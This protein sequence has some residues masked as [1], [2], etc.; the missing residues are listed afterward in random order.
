MS[1]IVR[2]IEFRVLDEEKIKKIH[3]KSLYIME[4]I[5]MR[6][7]GKRAVDLLTAHGARL[8]AD[9]LMRIGADMVE[10]ALQSAPKKLVLYNRSGEEAM[11]IDSENSQ[12]Y[13]GTHSDQ[14][15]IVDPFD[16]GVRKF[17]KKDVATMCRIAN[18]LPHIHFVLSVGMT[19]DV[20]PRVQT[21]STFI[22]TLRHFSKTI[23]FSSNNIDSLKDCLNIAADF[24]GGMQ[25]LQEK[26]F[27]FYYCEPIPPL[28]HPPDSTEKAFIS[29]EHRIPLIYMPYCMM[30]GTSPI[31][32]AT[33]LAQSN[34][35]VLFGL[36]LSQLVSE[37][38][39]Y[40][41]GAMPSILDM[42]T[43]IG[44]Y[45]APEFHLCVAA[46]A[47][48]A[49]YYGLPFYGTAGCSDAKAVD[50]QSVSE[51]T[52]QILS[53]MLSK[54]NLIHDVG[55]LD[56]CNNVSPEMVVLANEIIEMMKYYTRGVDAGEDDFV[57]D[58]V[59]KVGPGGHYIEE[60]HTLENFRQIWYPDI[61]SREKVTQPGSSI[62]QKIRQKIKGILENGAGPTL[63]PGQAEVL[64]EWEKKLGL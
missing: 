16:G 44:S 47:D 33:T 4:K 23:N 52:F 14:L 54:A 10:K 32:L 49:A 38:T 55:V 57:L 45:A 62:R 56:H 7:G 30:G 43:T 40:I 39:P 41:Y 1:Q 46:M 36:V 35:E 28:T 5:G 24:A 2:N 31:N 19:A 18:A 37:G 6:V 17:L 61:F 64:D 12:V 26:P 13:F 3:E 21:Q 48:L 11:V 59:E 53:T 9:G 34:A 20:D 8:G 50:E 22:E 42:R 15:E 27:I 60:M 51:V 63:D 58:L 25:K 29:A